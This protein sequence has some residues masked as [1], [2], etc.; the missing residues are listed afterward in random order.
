MS[1]LR[2]L[3]YVSRIAEGV[4]DRAIRNILAISRRNNR[5]LDVTGCLGCTG[6]Y[7]AQVLEGREEALAELARRIAADPRHSEFRL[8]LDR[9]VTLREHPLWAMAFVSALGLDDDLQA[10]FDGTEPSPRKTLQLMAR[11]KPD[12]V[13]GAL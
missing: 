1:T 3:F 13:M 8:L 11:I 5:M 4:D 9:S 2:Q 10:L 7:F 6:S 12:T